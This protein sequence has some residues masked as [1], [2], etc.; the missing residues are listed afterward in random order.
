MASGGGAALTLVTERVDV[1]AVEAGLQTG[2]SAIHVRLAVGL[3]DK[4]EDARDIV[5]LFRVSEDT[6][7]ADGLGGWDFGL[8]GCGVALCL[9]NVLSWDAITCGGMRWLGR[10]VG[11]GGIATRLTVALLGLVWLLLGLSV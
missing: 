8:L 2:N 4:V 9:L 1:E 6:L 7:G 3:L 5:L 10:G 11:G